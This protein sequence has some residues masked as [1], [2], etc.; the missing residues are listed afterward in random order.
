MPHCKI[1]SIPCNP[2]ENRSLPCG[3]LR[4][5]VYQMAEREARTAQNHG[6]S[7]YDANGSVV[8]VS[9]SV[10]MRRVQSSGGVSVFQ[11]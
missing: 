5:F 6:L 11:P 3:R 7:L 8:K 4:F 2:N 9:H 10:R 1:E